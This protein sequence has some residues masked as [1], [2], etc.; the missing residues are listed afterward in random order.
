ML[1]NKKE[2]KPFIK[3][4]SP[5]PG[6]K[7]VEIARPQPSK[8]F[9]PEGWLGVPNLME[10]PFPNPDD[11]YK[12][13]GENSMKRTAKT[14]PSFLDVWKEGYVIPAPCDIYLRW[15]TK[16]ETY[17]YET[18]IPLIPIVIHSNAQY[19]EHVQAPMHEFIFK[20]DNIWSIE[21]PKGY[22][23]RQIPMFWHHN[24]YWES[25][26]GIIHTDTYHQINIQIMLRKGV[27][28][29]VIQQGEPMCYVVP[30]R[31][32]D[33]DLQYV[34]FDMGLLNKADFNNLGIFDGT[35]YSK[36]HREQ[37]K[38]RKAQE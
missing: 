6:L 20:M 21:T 31:R 1:F 2:E 32:E 4:S 5:I 17:H 3:F 22:S 29:V 16:L 14:C 13:V 33:Y 18:A 35:T 15:D 27:T 7:D 8:K 37:E 11:P 28:E 34:D 9:I 25:A 24:P 26:Y 23:I 38:K 30:Y 10:P 19:L 36:F 12:F